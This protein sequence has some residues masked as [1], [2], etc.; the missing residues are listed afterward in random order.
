MLPVPAFL[1]SLGRYVTRPWPLSAHITGLRT[2][3]QT[4]GWSPLSAN[5]YWSE[6]KCVLFSARDETISHKRMCSCS[7]RIQ[8]RNLLI[9]IRRYALTSFGLAEIVPC[10]SMCRALNNEQGGSE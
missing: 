4:N 1:V 3:A 7:F 8:P 6:P 2:T 9:G 5:D 10:L